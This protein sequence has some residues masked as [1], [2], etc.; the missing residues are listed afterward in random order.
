MDEALGE[1]DITVI[2]TE[3]DIADIDLSQ[4]NDSFSVNF[5]QLGTE[6]KIIITKT[7]KERELGWGKDSKGY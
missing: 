1:H 6:W 5:K 7:F 2:C 3:E 4:G